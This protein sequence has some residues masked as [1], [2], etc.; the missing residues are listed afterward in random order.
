MRRKGHD[1]RPVQASAGWLWLSRAISSYIYCNTTYA[2]ARSFTRVSVTSLSLSLLACF[3]SSSPAT[4]RGAA[5]SHQSRLR[6]VSDGVKVNRRHHLVHGEICTGRSC[7]ILCDDKK[8]CGRCGVK[9]DFFTVRSPRCVE[10]HIR[11]RQNQ[12]SP[13]IFSEY[14]ISVGMKYC[15]FRVPTSITNSILVYKSKIWYSNN[16]P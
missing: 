5:A 3:L 1:C 10:P 4:R 13:A 15:V 9:E 2:R 7:R 11:S 8:G 14:R 16:V 12:S 6:D